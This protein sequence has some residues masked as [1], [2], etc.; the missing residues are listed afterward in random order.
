MFAYVIFT[1][2][3]STRTTHLSERKLLQESLRF[4][5]LSEDELVVDLDAG[6]A[7]LGNRQ[8]LLGPEVA[9]VGEECLKKSI[10]MLYGVGGIVGKAPAHKQ[11]NCI[12][13]WDQVMTRLTFLTLRQGKTAH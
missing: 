4:V 11:P 5:G 10:L 8:D 9:G 7:H 1:H 6:V 3:C 12:L 13:T 2:Y